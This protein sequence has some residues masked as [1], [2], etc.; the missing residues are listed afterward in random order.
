MDVV[1]VIVKSSGQLSPSIQLSVRVI[2]LN[3]VSQLLKKSLN[4]EN[5]ALILLML[6]FTTLISGSLGLVLFWPLK[7]YT[8]CSTYF[9]MIDFHLESYLKFYYG[10]KTEIETGENRNRRNSNYMLNLACITI[11]S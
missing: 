8:D 11:I 1:G 6:K 7:I 3:F 10:M 4:F 9:K 2:T 5:F